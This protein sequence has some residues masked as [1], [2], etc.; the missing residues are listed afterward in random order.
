MMDPLLFLQDLAV[1]I[2]S[3][4]IGGYICRRIGLSSIVGYITAGLV[5]GTPDIVFPYVTDE[6]RISTIAQLGVVFLMFSI[7]LKFSLRRVRELGLRTVVATA[8]TAFFVF[9]AARIGADIIGLSAPAGI[10]LA[11][12]F[13]CSSSAIISKLIEDTGLGHARHGQLAL[14]IT[15]LEDIVAVVMLAVLGSYIVIEGGS[16]ARHPVETVGLL[17]GFAVLVFVLGSLLL[18]RMLRSASARGGSEPVSVLVAGLLLAISLLAVH[19][20]YSLALGAFLCGMVVAETRQKSLVERSFQGLKDIFLTI[21]FVTIGMMVDVSAIPGALKWIVLG[22][23]GALAGRMLAAFIALLLIGEH[24]RTAFRAALCLTPL[25]EFSFIIAGVAVGGG[26]LSEGFQVAA[27]GTVLC[28]SLLSPWLATRGE[29]LS[30]FLAEGEIAL[31][32]RAHLAYSQLWRVGEGSSRL[33]RMWMLLRKRV[34]QI[35]IELLLVSTV[36]IFANELF[37]WASRVIPDLYDIPHAEII[38]W[39][40]LAV[41]CTV[42]LLAIWR[43]LSAT[44]EILA[45]GFGGG[46]VAGPIGRAFLSVG[47]RIIFAFLL[48]VWMWNILPTELP[49]TLILG[50][51]AIIAIP[52]LLLAWRRFIRIHSEMEWAL[53]QNLKTTALASNKHLFDNWKDQGWNLNVKEFTIPDESSLAGKTLRDIRFRTT[54]G[55]SVVGI[56]RHGYPLATVAPTTH[57]FPGDEILLLGDEQQLRK[58]IELLGQTGLPDAT[59]GSMQSQVVKSL[60][61][62]EGSPVASQRLEALNWPRTYGVQVIAIMRAGA[63]LTGLDAKSEVRPGDSLLLLGA[64]S[65]MAE[66]A[67]KV[68]AVEASK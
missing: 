30:R 61:V 23:V 10:A 36:L 44:A 19:A 33:N 57:L 59:E 58:A 26:L 66:I 68:A 42:P 13:M 37:N 18:P 56:Q 5:V 50:I 9:S 31:L 29:R 60:K 40:V 43:N 54:T 47:L 53:D 17:V 48:I 22:T 62:P 24:P 3:A 52:L 67:E 38:F 32:D 35:G 4:S 12:I 25:G 63:M 7:G 34:L 1:I 11:G 14:G 15:L 8:L 64:S 16:V 39:S 55:A 2:L 21:F 65:Q 41:A 49:R 46:A 20:G 27:V 45:E 28:T 6:E 51:T